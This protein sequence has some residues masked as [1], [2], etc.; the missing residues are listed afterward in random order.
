LLSSPLWWRPA[1]DLLGHA[2]GA[3]VSGLTI[4]QRVAVP[5]LGYACGTC[6]HCLTGWETLCLQQLD[7]GY[8][9]DGCYAEYFLA[10][11]AF[12]AK[13]PDRIDPFDAAPLSCAG[14]TVLH[15]K[16]KARIVMTP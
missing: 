12:A 5:W 2:T 13:V 15:G 11:A 3:G 4:G 10:E 8:S 9:V 14:V 1:D 6:K 16:A 7:T